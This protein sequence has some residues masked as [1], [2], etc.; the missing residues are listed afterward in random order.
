[1]VGLTKQLMP[2]AAEL[3]RQVAAFILREL[4]GFNYTSVETK[5]VNQ[6][7]SYVDKTA[8]EMLVKGFEKL[9]PGCG[10][11]TEENTVTPQQKEY[12][13]IID[14]LD[15][16]TN[17]VHKV[18]VFS[19]SA[20]LYHAGELVAGLVMDV[21][22]N[23]LFHGSKGSGV[24]CNDKPVKISA[25]PTLSESLLAT[26]FPYYDFEQMQQYLAVLRTLLKKTHG[27]RRMGSAAIDLAYTACG[28]FDGFFEYSLSP[29]DVAA[30]AFLVKEAGGEVTDFM[31]GEDYLFGKTIVA[32][33]PLVMPELSQIIA[34]GFAVRSPNRG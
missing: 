1:M 23:E 5:S 17:F 30:G 27:L 18:P 25:V 24:F 28:R 26:G 31:G 33:N 34:S 16:T 4:E 7:V 9:M 2:G 29:W 14:P 11:I 8:E 20:G 21:C 13:W 12:T 32:G 3:I 22:G 15:G 10:F 19:V 6:L